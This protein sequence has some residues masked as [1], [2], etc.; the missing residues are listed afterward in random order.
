MA[1]STLLTSC[2]FSSAAATALPAALAEPPAAA[3][4]ALFF[5][6]PIATATAVA[7]KL[8]QARSGVVM[9]LCSAGCRRVGLTAMLICVMMC[10]GSTTREQ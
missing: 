7:S 9:L 6:L 8:Q 3:A 2:C 4:E 10:E 5:L 1:L